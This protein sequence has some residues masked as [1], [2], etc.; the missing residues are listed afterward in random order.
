MVL[1]YP[2]TSSSR[3]VGTQIIRDHQL[4]DKAI[5]LEEFAHQFQRRMLIL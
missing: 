3:Y 5:L 4:R 2:K 1:R